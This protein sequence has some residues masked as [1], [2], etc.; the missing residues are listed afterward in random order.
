MAM[1]SVFIFLSTLLFLGAAETVSASDVFSF[2][3]LSD[4]ATLDWNRAHTPIE[5]YLMINL[6]EGLVTYETAKDGSL[7]VVPALAESWKMSADG[8]T[9]TFKLR[10]GVKWSDGVALK[11]ADFEYSWKRLLTASTAASYAYLLFEVQGA[12]DYFKGI[13]KDWSTVGIKAIDDSTLQIKLKQPVAYFIHIPTFW[14]TFPLR[15]DVVEKN[16]T[17]WTRPGKMVTVGPY[18]LSAYEIDSKIVLDPNPHYY[19]KRGNVK[20]AVGLIVKEDT[21]A[22]SLYESGKI[23]FMTDISATDL[24]R[25][26]GRADL[27]TF[28]YFKTGYFGFTALKDPASNVK[29]RRAISMAIDRKKIEQVLKGSQ[30]TATSF[31]PPRMMSYQANVGLKFD[32]AQAKAELKASGINPST[33]SL[34]IL[35]SNWEKPVKIAQFIQAELKTNLGLNVQIQAFDHKTFRSQLDLKSYPLFINSWSADY[36]DPDNFMSIWL[37]M[38]GNNW[39]GWK[40]KRYDEKV[41][42][43]RTELNV[44]A[45]AKLYADAQKLLLEDEAVIL[46]LYYEPNLALVKPRVKNLE[47]NPLNYFY[48]KKV[49]LG[50]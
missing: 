25:L 33:T 4:P 45:R 36:P 29:L 31:I 14:V 24:S 50:N 20:Q 46:P 19:G 28:P 13:N 18:V 6:M 15:K 37:S 9:Y 12:E 7:K 30:Q 2:R 23:D 48:I 35:C 39:A 27:K 17:S 38:A 49:N 44:K 42:K 8:K 5:N 1:R 3:L 11:A 22:L 32:P 16:P 26:K 43:A 41:L 40:D 34:E 21:T 47:L 10:P